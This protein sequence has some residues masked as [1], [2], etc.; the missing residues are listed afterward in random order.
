MEEG[1]KSCKTAGD[2]SEALFDGGPDGDI[3]CIPLLKS[4]R[5]QFSGC[6]LTYRESRRNS[7]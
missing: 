6:E 7:A 3:D 1:A 4:A 5:A 2:D